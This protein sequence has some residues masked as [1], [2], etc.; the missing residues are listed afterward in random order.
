[1]SE[2]RTPPFCC[3]HILPQKPFYKHEF[4][5]RAYTCVLDFLLLATHEPN[6]LPPTTLSKALQEHDFVVRLCKGQAD[7]R[8]GEGEPRF[9]ERFGKSDPHVGQAGAPRVGPIQWGPAR[10]FLY[11]P[12]VQGCLVEVVDSA[13]GYRSSSLET[14]EFLLRGRGGPFGGFLSFEDVQMTILCPVHNGTIWF[15]QFWAKGP[16]DR[17]HLEEVT[18]RVRRRL[19]KEPGFVED[20]FTVRFNEMMGFPTRAVQQERESSR[21]RNIGD[22][23]Y[24]G[25]AGDEFGISNFNRGVDHPVSGGVL[26]PQH[27]IGLIVH[28]PT[29]MN[30]GYAQARRQGFLGTA[31]QWEDPEIRAVFTPHLP[32][33]APPPGLPDCHPDTLFHSPQPSR[34]LDMRNMLQGFQQATPDFLPQHEPVLERETYTTWRPEPPLP[35]LLQRVPRDNG[36]EDISHQIVPGSNRLPTSKLASSGGPLRGSGLSSRPTRAVLREIGG[37][38]NTLA[39]DAQPQEPAEPA[40]LRDTKVSDALPC[41]PP[42]SDPSGLRRVERRAWN[43]GKKEWESYWVWST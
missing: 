25:N 7:P 34:L 41:T 30:E 29:T 32:N 21:R 33:L 11:D 10:Y 19:S 13:N 39:S 23:T 8:V 20:P 40:R 1:M 28:P 2:D 4:Y 5:P 9:G 38:S 36:W 15:L 22:V 35:P 18:Q 37:L 6:Y 42:L 31:L 17:A 27:K 3:Q 24:G 43:D 26:H 12:E 14:L 16:R